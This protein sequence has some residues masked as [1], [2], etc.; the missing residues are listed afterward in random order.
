MFLQQTKQEQ[1]TSRWDPQKSL[2][3][4]GEWKHLKLHIPGENVQT[5]D[6]KDRIPKFPLG[7]ENVPT[8]L[9]RPGSTSSG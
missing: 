2:P 1:L 3:S 4:E 5:N 8:L 6:L 9:P 7:K